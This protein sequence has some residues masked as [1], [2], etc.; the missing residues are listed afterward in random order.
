MEEG[1]ENFR[2]V[3]RVCL[4]KRFR[5]ASFDFENSEPIIR[6]AIGEWSRTLIDHFTSFRILM[7][8]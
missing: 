1:F 2:P 4:N 6:S 7:A 8:L 3:D 5:S